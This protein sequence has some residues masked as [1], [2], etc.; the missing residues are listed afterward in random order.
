[1]LDV[2]LNAFNM[3][4]REKV[5]MSLLSWEVPNHERISIWVM[6]MNL[7]RPTCF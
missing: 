3:A 4:K 5:G 2:D 6:T 1:M 7:R